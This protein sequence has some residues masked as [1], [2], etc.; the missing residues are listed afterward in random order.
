[1]TQAHKQLP[2]WAEL[3]WWEKSGD[4]AGCYSPSF[5]QILE[6]TTTSYLLIDC[7]PSTNVYIKQYLDVDM[8]LFS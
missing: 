1:M 4:T 6:Q 5:N 2:T 7:L 8:Q 3:V